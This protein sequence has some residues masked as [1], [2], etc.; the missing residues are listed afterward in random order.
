MKESKIFWDR[1]SGKYDNQVKRYEQTYQKT[2]EKTNQYLGNADTVLDFACGT[3][4]I[5]IEV[6]ESV[7][8]IHAIDISSKMIDV[9]KRKADEKKI[10][11]IQFSQTDIFDESFGNESFNTVLGFNILYFL[12]DIQNAV[13]RIY[14]LLLPGGLFISATDCLGEHRSIQS[15]L[16][17]CVSKIGIIPQMQRLK[18][19][20]LENFIRQGNFEIIET[21]NLYQKPPNYFIV[22]QKK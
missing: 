3:G 14:E 11:N 5:T 10:T 21:A 7:K 16:T 4:I 12:S 6:A 2:I 17:Y 13:K 1:L 18:I 19:S 20:E 22:A 9:A 15:V 8:T